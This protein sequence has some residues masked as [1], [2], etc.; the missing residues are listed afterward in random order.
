M[1]E[2][3]MVQRAREG[4]EAAFEALYS[5]NRS[6]VWRVFLR[7]TGNPAEAEE[8]TQDT[9]LQLYRKLHLFR[10]E[11][12]LSTFVYRIAVNVV[13]MG[14]RKKVIDGVSLDAM[15]E[16]SDERGEPR[17]D[18]GVVDPQLTMSPER[19]RF[20]A[21]FDALPPGYQIVFFLHDIQGYEHVEIAAM[22]DCSIGNSKSQLHKARARLV[23]LINPEMD[24]SNFEVLL[25][26][27][28]SREVATSLGAQ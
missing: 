14:R 25:A 17:F 5:A 9:F 10:G 26:E 27:Y 13:L 20:W 24:L 16:A 22:L 15:N 21:E 12:A 2:A 23:Q 7:M 1:T 19:V 18:E 4:D 3:E 8:F 11:S 28:A 6:G